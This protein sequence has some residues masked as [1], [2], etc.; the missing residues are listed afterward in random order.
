MLANKDFSFVS[1][2]IHLFK[3][4]VDIFDLH[5]SRLKSI[6]KNIPSFNSKTKN[7]K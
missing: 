6:N 5:M 3:K 7:E 4:L 1:N 2:L